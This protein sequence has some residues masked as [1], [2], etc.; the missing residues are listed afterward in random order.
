MTAPP[1]IQ[2]TARSLTLWLPSGNMVKLDESAWPFMLPA[3]DKEAAK[4]AAAQAGLKV[5]LSTETE[6]TA[7]APR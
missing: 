3:D 1:C 7:E 2:D 4:I 5:T 6:T